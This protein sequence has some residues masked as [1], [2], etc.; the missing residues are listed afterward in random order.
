MGA[1]GSEQLAWKQFPG[2][3]HI[4][5]VC[6]RKLRIQDVG[7]IRTYWEGKQKRTVFWC[8]EHRG[9]HE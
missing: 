5:D 4:C 8:V 9:G 3:P 2:V 1:K 6:R 7:E